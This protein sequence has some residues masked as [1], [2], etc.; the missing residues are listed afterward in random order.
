MAYSY[1]SDFVTFFS[2]DDPVFFTSDT[3]FSDANIIRLCG[4]PFSS[5]EEMDET[6]IRNWN[7]TVP[8]NGTVFHLGDFCSKS[9]S[10]WKEILGKLNGDVHLILGNHDLRKMSS[11]LS[12]LFASVGEQKQVIVGEQRIYLNHYPFLCYGGSYRDV[13]QLFGHVHT[14]PGHTGLDDHRMGALFPMQYDVGID[15]NGYHPVSFSRLKEIIG[16]RMAESAE[17]EF[18]RIKDSLSRL[19]P[20]EIV[21][22]DVSEKWESLFRSLKDRGIPAVA[23][24]Q[25]MYSFL[26]PHRKD[27]IKTGTIFTG[28]NGSY[29]FSVQYH[30]VKGLRCYSVEVSDGEDSRGKF[31]EDTSSD[32][33][34]EQ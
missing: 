4:R 29:K 6:I 13:W 14:G 31:R 9:A 25:E 8:E 32:G 21:G 3:H 17:K 18:A 34:N 22:N 27:R 19:R 5:V 2:E 1:N 10:R 33:E 11:E 24:R 7:S 26:C 16:E 28:E 23:D 15:N 12:S 20:D 30:E